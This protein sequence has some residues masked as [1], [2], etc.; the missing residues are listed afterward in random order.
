MCPH[1]FDIP[2]RRELEPFFF[3]FALINSGY[4]KNTYLHFFLMHL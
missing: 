1:Y 3:G 2:H 4:F